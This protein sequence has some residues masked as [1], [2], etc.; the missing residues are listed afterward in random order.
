[1]VGILAVAGILLVEAGIA[2]NSVVIDRSS[3]FEVGIVAVVGCW[4][5]CGRRV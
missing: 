2:G 5:G 3:R 1:M 4:D